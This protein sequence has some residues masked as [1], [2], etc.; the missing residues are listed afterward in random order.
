MGSNEVFF[1]FVSSSAQPP[2]CR[3]PFKQRPPIQP[4]HLPMNLSNIAF[5]PLT[6]ESEMFQFRTLHAE[7]FPLTYDENFYEA[8]FTGEVHTIL[9][10]F[11]DVILGSITFN[12]DRFDQ[13]P[14]GYDVA[15]SED[16]LAYIMTLGVVEEF[17]GRG[18]SRLLLE[19]AIATSWSIDNNLAGIY[20]HV[21][22]YN[23]AAISLYKSFGFEMLNI[24][25]NFYTIC[26]VPYS[27]LTYCLYPE[28]RSQPLFRTMWGSVTGWAKQNIVHW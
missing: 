24:K 19:K 1:G 27:A 6:E 4:N 25:E 3:L 15:E 26:G 22:E 11:G 23:Q 9:A 28:G 18:L 20:L 10:I 8:V 13:L 17:R 12:I 14:A 16:T 21:I 5:K 7:W 2:G